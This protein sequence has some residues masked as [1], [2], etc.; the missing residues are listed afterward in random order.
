MSFKGRTFGGKFYIGS[1]YSGI[2]SKLAAVPK[3]IL[4]SFTQLNGT[5]I[6][7]NDLINIKYTVT[8]STSINFDVCEL[9]NLDQ[10]VRTVFSATETTGDISFKVE[11]VNTVKIALVNR[12]I[13]TTYEI[14]VQTR[15]LR[16]L[17]TDFFEDPISTILHIKL[18]SNWSEL[19]IAKNWG[20]EFVD[21]ALIDYDSFNSSFLDELRNL[22]ISRQLFNK[23]EADSLNFIDT[24]CNTFYL[25]SKINKNGY[26]TISYL[27]PPESL[28]CDLVTLNESDYISEIKE[29]SPQDLFLEPVLNYA[30]DYM[31]GEYTKQLAITNIDKLEWLPEYSPGFTLSDG[32]E[33]WNTLKEIYSLNPIITPIPQNLQNQILIPD[34]TTAVWK[35]K[36]IIEWMQKPRCSIKVPY[37][38]GNFWGFGTFIKIK[39]PHKTGNQEIRCIIEDI[40]KDKKS[41][42]DCKLILIDKVTNYPNIEVDHEQNTIGVNEDSE[43]FIIGKDEET[44]NTQNI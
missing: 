5:N 38:I 7:Q 13:I 40:T 6:Q 19:G 18:L 20:K 42:I 34:Y 30:Y 39:H 24:I 26:E 43:Q 4:F 8:D 12:T 2:V 31:T 17:P 36:K 28:E 27:F 15:R 21:E 10:V 25:I 41:N 33:V 32:E 44:E 9:N 3:E 37:S 35:I 29:P 22:K 14:E 11:N 23:T 1:G 16:I